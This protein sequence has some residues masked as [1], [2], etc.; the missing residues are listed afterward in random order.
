MKKV[1]IDA[2]LYSQTGV[3]VYLRNLLYYLDKIKTE[4]IRFY[5]YLLNEDFEKVNFLNKNFIK[6][7]A[8][9]YWHTVVEQIGFLKILNKDNLDLMH[10]TYFS[11]PILYKKKYLATVHDL[12]PLYFKTGKASTKNQLLYEIKHL[13]FK[14]VLK[15]QVEK[16]IKIIT[17]TRTVKNQLINYYGDFLKNKTEFFYE[18]VN[19]ELLNAQENTAL[20][21]QFSN[22]FFIYVGNFYPHKNIRNL[23]KAFSQI[24][25]KDYRLILIG[26][27]DFFVSELYYLINQ[28]KQD[29]RIIFYHSQA[30]SDLIFFYKN[31]QALIHPSLSEGFGLPIVEAMNFNLPILASNIPVFKEI[32]KDQYLSFIPQKI[33]DITEKINYFI[34]NQKKFDYQSLL[35][36]YSFPLMTKKIL[37]FYQS[38]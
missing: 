8:N 28:L 9:Y 33:E 37:A 14:K 36:K 6:R 12:T 31:A 38:L 22:K 20:K 23:I 1:G 34:R 16:A 3:G 29:E 2:R 11:F 18:G 35:K 27:N 4:N 5:I 19:Y 17:P 32:L 21:K 15:T 26:P 10:F 24:K 7:R 30:I 13:A 25:D